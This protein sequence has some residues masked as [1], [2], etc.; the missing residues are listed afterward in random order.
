MAG[1]LTSRFTHLDGLRGIFAL[2]VAINHIEGSMTGWSL[3]RPCA[4][5]YLAVDYFFILSG[6]VLTHML[7][8]TPVTPLVF[9]KKRLFRLWPLHAITTLLIFALFVNNR[10]HGQFFPADIPLTA[11][12]LLY[13]LS[14]VSG[15][16]FTSR[17]MLN[18]PAWSISVE[19]WISGLILYWLTKLGPAWLFALAALVYAMIFSGG[20]GLEATYESV[21]H[22]PDVMLRGVAGMVLGVALYKSRAQLEAIAAAMGPR[23]FAW[24]LA[25][26][27]VLIVWALWCDTG[28]DFDF[29]PLTAIIPFFALDQTGTTG[30]LIKD[31]LTSL[32]LQWLGRISFPLYLVH[33]SIVILGAPGLYIRFLGT[34]PTL[35]L[36]LGL[37]T[38][39]A[40]VLERLL[41]RPAGQQR[42]G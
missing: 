6:F 40:E 39:A 19:F 16:G 32:P 36:F 34:W 25:V 9:F 21:W 23:A 41:A 28:S 7:I 26:V 4:G 31:F 12:T 35:F 3:T 10:V 20:T 2:S 22:M 13:N 18:N 1:A 24:G 33:N 27:S 17:A 8:K 14:F 5:A 30:G 37:S 15:T 42:L 11:K 38:L 29:I